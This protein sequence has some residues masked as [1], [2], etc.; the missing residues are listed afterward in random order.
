LTTP[1]IPLLPPPVAAP[2]DEN[3]LMRC[4]KELVDALNIV[5]T[6]L[7]Q[8]T[9]TIMSLEVSAGN[10]NAW[11]IIGTGTPGES[12]AAKDVVY[13]KASD[14]RWWKAK[15]DASAT[16]GPV[17]VALVI[18]GGAAAATCT[19]LHWGTME[20]TGWALTAGSLYYISTGTAGLI[21]VTAP[22]STG[23]QVRAL[24]HALTTTSF[25]F[26]P[27]SDFGEKT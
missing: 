16:S 13:F 8:R 21:T 9:E 26:H 6:R 14:S 22:S 11:G 15:A 12:L 18:T 7:A 17:A 10:G 2:V 23:H 3:D 1:K 20:V 27:S 5:Y 4:A 24:G 19:L 25:F